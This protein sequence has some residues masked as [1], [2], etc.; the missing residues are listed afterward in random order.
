M[1]Y[2]HLMPLSISSENNFIRPP[3]TSIDIPLHS[4]W[5]IFENLKMIIKG[6]RACSHHLDKATQTMLL[7][8]VSGESLDFVYFGIWWVFI[9]LQERKTL[10]FITCNSDCKLSLLKSFEN[11]GE[12]LA[13]HY[14]DFWCDI[15]FKKW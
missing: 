4:A 7:E 8:S 10:A 2:D 15:H 5:D 6:W 13:L 12:N 1:F 14:K 11:K 3:F 9:E